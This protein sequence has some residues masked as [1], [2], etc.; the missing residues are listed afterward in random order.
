MSLQIALICGPGHERDRLVEALS[1][2]GDI[3]ADDH[4]RSNGSPESDVCVIAVDARDLENDLTIAARSLSNGTRGVIVLGNLEEAE[5]E[6]LKIYPELLSRQL[7]VAVVPTPSM[8]KA[9]VIRT[10]QS[11]SAG[12]CPACVDIKGAIARSTVRTARRQ[13]P[14]ADG[15]DRIVL[16][17]VWGTLVFAAIMT[18]LFQSVFLFASYPMNA[19][20]QVLNSLGREVS[21]VLPEGIFRSFIADGLIGGAGSIFVFLPQI[22]ILFF[23]LAL[24]ERTGYM[25]RAARLMDGAMRRFGL[26]GYSF[27]SLLNSLACAVPGILST[28]VIPSRQSRLRTILIVP[29]IGCSATLPVYTLLIAALIPEHYV[30]PFISVQGLVLLGLYALGMIMAVFV[31]LVLKVL[32]GRKEATEVEIEIPAW[33]LPS[34]KAVGKEVWLR[35]EEFVRSAGKLI[36]LCALLVWFLASF[37]RAP[38]GTPPSEQVGMSYAGQFGHFI[39]PAVRPLGYGWEETVALIMS[40]A[41]REAFVSTLATVYNL[42]DE[43][44]SGVSLV[45]ILRREHEAGN[46]SMATGLSLLVFFVFACQCSSTLVTC[47]KETRSWFWTGVLFTYTLGLA[48]VCAWLTYTVAAGS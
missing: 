36:V 2:I 11:G 47:R 38:A 12:H 6:G 5:S 20:T 30:L 25:P 40:F 26:P 31:S 41:R 14:F 13:S 44:G 7:N 46:F 19:I 33:S 32:L 48:Y 8:L 35:V 4:N 9:E 28:R 24:L 45:S 16:H 43:P 15:L 10:A 22:A 37:P 17:P 21:R 29:L 23:F 34:M 42:K 3:F 18:V 27:I 39:E 1:S